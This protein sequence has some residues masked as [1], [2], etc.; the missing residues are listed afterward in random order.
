M[1]KEVL[2][3]RNL[4]IPYQEKRQF[5]WVSLILFEGECTAFFGLSF[6]GKDDLVSSLTSGRPCAAEELCLRID[7]EPVRDQK[8]LEKSVYRLS[9]R[10]QTLRGWNLAEYIALTGSGWMLV[11]RQ[12]RE[13]VLRAQALT[14]ELGLSLDVRRELGTLSEKEKMLGELARACALGAR[15]LVV[16]D[17]LESLKD[18]EIREFAGA[19]HSVAEKRRLT[20]IINAHSSA[21]SRALADHY[22]I[23]RD[24]RIVKKCRKD[25]ILSPQMLE[26]YM[27][28]PMTDTRQDFETADPAV[29]GGKEEI[30]YR[31]RSFPSGSH[32]LR[33]LRGSSLF[34]QNGSLLDLSFRKSRVSTF[35]VPD[36]KLRDRLFLSLSG[37]DL[38]EQ[39]YCVIGDM[40][41]GYGEY[42]RFVKNRVVSVMH[43]GSREELFD[44]MSVGEN[45]VLPSIRKIS[46]SDYLLS[47]SRLAYAL[48]PNTAIGGG[49]DDAMLSS[50]V[51]TRIA[52]TL[53]RWNLYNPKVMVLLEPFERCDLYGV[54]IVCSYVRRL[55]GR[56]ACVILIKSRAEY[57]EDIS[58]EMLRFE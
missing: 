6:S 20:V 8:M 41:M 54:S 12:R 5:K 11:G 7:S 49:L 38:S 39:T 2:C 30:L 25:E 4:N 57:A 17:E 28:G 1:K 19:L 29:S 23:F 46:F 36:E 37:R 35:L 45:L 16:E 13:L 24:G 18:E 52:V 44:N 26:T 27:L 40:R 51:N 34:Q 48:E 43:L 9:P 50:D 3:I 58:D 10:T 32:R 15:V 56:G 33:P 31:M 42:L 14:E 21:V 47:S 22:V 53:E 55:S